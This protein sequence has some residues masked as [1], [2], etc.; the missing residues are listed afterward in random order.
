MSDPFLQFTQMLERSQWW[1]PARLEALQRKALQRIL[2]HAWQQ[3]PAYR[4]RL[5]PLFAAGDQT[6]LSRWNDIPVLTRKVAQARTEEFYARQ[7]PDQAGESFEQQTSGSTGMPL[8][9]RTSAL[10][11][12]ASQAAAARCLDWYKVDPDKSCA[13]FSATVPGASDLPDGTMQREWQ[14]GSPEG[15]G[16][17]LDHKLTDS[18]QK[19]A[20]LRRNPTTYLA[21]TPNTALGIVLEAQNTHSEAPRYEA[22]MLGGEMLTPHTDTILRACLSEILINNYGSEECGRMAVC[23]PEHQNFHLHEEFCLIEILDGEDRAVEPGQT[24]RVVVTPFYNF[25]MP[26]IR[27]AIGDYATLSAEPCACGRSS[28]TLSK[29]M[30]R[31]RHLFRFGNGTS[32]WPSLRVEEFQAIVPFQQWQIVQDRVDH[33]S[34][35][36]ILP[37]TDILFDRTAFRI[38]I[39]SAFRQQVDVDITLVRDIPRDSSGKFE[40]FKS[41]L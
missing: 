23:C 21:A 7:V 33:L 11:R 10:Q 4:E 30:G 8:R 5:G 35:C 40:E 14:R 22:L 29:I 24:G 31:E 6:D 41:T 1:E 26:L 38:A 9:H 39:C 2:I 20:W 25:A 36:L 18:A 28:R 3:A 32:F 15:T 27:Y 12:V 34:I 13:H 19:L 17:W 37:D 16:Y